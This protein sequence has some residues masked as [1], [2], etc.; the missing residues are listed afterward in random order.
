M[1]R[2]HV[3]DLDQEI[4]IELPTVEGRDLTCAYF[5][6]EAGDWEALKCA[7]EVVTEASITCCTDH[8]TRFALVPIE[9]LEVVRVVQE[10]KENQ[11]V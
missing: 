2:F 1:H 3:S 7:N 10:T 9:Y 11:V 6:E 8:L 4:T 5:N